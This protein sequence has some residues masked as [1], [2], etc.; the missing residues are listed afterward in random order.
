MDIRL[1][2]DA[3]RETEILVVAVANFHRNPSYWQDRL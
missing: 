3:I 2:D 1:L